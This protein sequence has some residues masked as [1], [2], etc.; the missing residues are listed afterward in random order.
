MGDDLLKIKSFGLH[1]FH[2]LQM[3]GWSLVHSEGYFSATLDLW[4]VGLRLDVAT[5]GFER[6]VDRTAALLSSARRAA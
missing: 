3:A 5:A 4:W 6:V 1:R 2:D